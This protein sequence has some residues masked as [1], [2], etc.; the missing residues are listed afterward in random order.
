MT[1]EIEN[2][3]KY[4]AQVVSIDNETIEKAVNYSKVENICKN[5]YLIN[6][7]MVK[8]R[9]HLK[10]IGIWRD[11]EPSGTEICTVGYRY[12]KLAD[13]KIIGHWALID[14]KIDL[15]PIHYIC[16]LNKKWRSHE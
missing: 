7:V 13:N 11:I 4:L 15:A 12:L 5:D 14:G 9:M 16:S 6:K 8:I 2:L 3:K 10:H 1:K